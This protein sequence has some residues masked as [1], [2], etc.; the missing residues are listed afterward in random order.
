[1]VFGEYLEKCIREKN[2]SI[3]GLTRITGINRG[4]LYSV[5][6]GERSLKEDKLFAIIENIG[7]SVKEEQTLTELYFREVFG[8]VSFDKIK[9]VI[10]AIEKLSLS[11]CENKETVNIFNKKFCLIGKEEILSAL[12]YII[13]N[14]GESKIITN[15]SCENRK[16]DNLFYSFVKK[17]NSE[18]LVHVLSL[19]ERSSELNNLNAIF[20]S[21]KYMYLKSFPVCQYENKNEQIYPYFAVSD[22]YAL[23]YN[24][25]DGIFIDEA[26]AVNQ[27]LTK[28]KNVASK[29]SSLGTST[30]DIMFVKNL[31]AKSISKS[32]ENSNE[33]INFSGYPCIVLY[34]DY[35]LMYSITRGDLPQKDYLVNIAYNHYKSLYKDINYT[36]FFSLDGIDRFVETGNAMEIPETYVTNLSKEYRLKILNAILQDIE[37]EKIY[38]VNDEKLR[39]PKNLEIENYFNK[40]I[41]SMFDCEKSNFFSY[42]KFISTINDY[43]IINTFKMLKE[44][45]IRARMVYPKKYAAIYVKNLIVKLENMDI[46]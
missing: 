14:C 21:L 34:A 31:Y 29:C 20:S 6:K 26:N 11:E 16:I 24:D 1:M 45:L 2:I 3:S 37:N 38:I 8:S 40:V 36:F 7:F 5:F 15:F 32:E 42:D 17:G 12:N 41:I 9:Y 35:D 44:Y 27:I 43:D 28:V 33:L 25:N 22:K 18:K 46:Q 19:L 10:N 4:G 30:D 13:D 39:I 23:L